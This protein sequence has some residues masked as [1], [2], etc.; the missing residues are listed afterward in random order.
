MGTAS[1]SPSAVGGITVTHPDRIVYPHSR[2]T[3]RA[4]VRYY[5]TIAEQLLA[6]VAGRPL[7]IVR[8][9]RGIVATRFF[10]RHYTP[11]LGAHVHTVSVVE[12]SGKTA[13]Y[14]YIDDERGLL[15]LAQMGTIELHTWGAQAASPEL[16]NR[17]IFDLDP[18]VGIA[19]QAMI[20][21]ASQVRSELQR[22]KLESFVRLTGGKG[23]HVVA[24]FAT[25]P[26]WNHVGAFCKKLAAHMVAEQPELFVAAAAKARR[27]NRIFID[28]LR[29]ARGATSIA[30][31]SLRARPGAPAAVPLRWEELAATRS[32]SDYD[33]RAARQRAQRVTRDP[34]ARFGQLQ[35]VLS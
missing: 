16:P 12:R 32:G 10:Q 3:K 24:P 23:L 6:E 8:C 2:I 30:N 1:S 7:S 22:A 19:W 14:F 21:A 20:A 26:S 18:A 31:W 5:A 29:N 17:V 35:Q 33:L 4:V 28:W 15:E 11:G 27:T 25:G 34:W 13:P 9:P